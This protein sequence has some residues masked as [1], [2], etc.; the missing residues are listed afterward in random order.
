MKIDEYEFPDELYYEEHHF[1]VRD[2]GETLTL[3]ITDYAQKL[4]GE[5]IFIE[6][7]E[8]DQKITKGKPFT[9]IE[10]GK[11]VGR[12]YAPVNGVIV[13]ANEAL[14]DDATLMNSSPYGDGW[15]CKI[16]PSNKDELK[17]LMKTS[18]AKFKPWM[19]EEIEKN[20]PKE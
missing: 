20:V 12:V 7:P 10:S 3:G 2:E 11:W 13:E 8:E 15:I 1:W 4:A 19:K 9:S 14:D 18:D 16:K 17:D 6:L 5:F